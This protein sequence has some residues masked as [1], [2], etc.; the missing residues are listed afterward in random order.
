[1]KWR[2]GVSFA[3]IYTKGRKD[4]KLNYKT[5]F[6]YMITGLLIYFFSYLS[7]LIKMKITTLALLYMGL[8]S[9][10]FLLVLTGGILL[11]R[12]IKSKINNKDIF[13]GK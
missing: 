4:E 5:A 1:M 6:A 10:G 2:R 12:I 8:S 7:L 11:S 9:T 3:G 13:K